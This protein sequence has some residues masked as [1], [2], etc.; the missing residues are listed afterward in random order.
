MNTS[1]NIPDIRI[2]RDEAMSAHVDDLLK[3]QKSLLGESGIDHGPRHWYYRSW[4]VLMLVGAM[5]A[6]GAWAL[7][8][9]F[10]DDTPY[11]QG[12]I[13]AM[14]LDAAIPTRI[15]IGEQVVD[16]DLKGR[17]WIQVRNEKIWLLDGTRDILADETTALL[18][19]AALQRGQE[20]GVHA[21]Y[22]EFAEQ[23]LAVA[24]FVL[25]SPPPDPPA[26]AS[27]SLRRQAV[28]ADVWSLLLFP[29]VAGFIGLAI[30]AVDGIICRTPRRALL[31]GV[32]GCVV[33][34]VGGAVSSFLGN[35]VYAPLTRLA[36]SEMSEAEGLTAFGFMMQMGA[37]T[38]AW[39]LV[40]MAMGLGQGIALRS[41][42]LLAYGF[43]GG[44]VGGLLG[45]LFFDP[46]D[47]L[48]L[49]MD[50]P[51]AHWSRLVGITAI[52]ACVGAMIGVVELLARDAWLRM[53]EGPLAGKE[54]LIFKDTMKLGSSA[55]AEIYLFNDPMVAEHHATLR[56]V[57]DDCEIENHDAEHPVLVNNRAVTVARLRRG[58]RITIGRT[59]FVY[60][61]RRG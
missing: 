27:F 22:Q 41:K 43:M 60:E 1:G 55:R 20:V 38:L 24:R 54:F 35:L 50:K 44:V 40:G 26:K 37:R 14:D 8:E 34:F 31:G 59:A 3:R 6:F 11:L 25:T 23:S 30:G 28:R 33:G 29:V 17:G 56:A 52:G 21:H 5:A 19:R 13:E 15:T 47:L 10:F 36:T 51:S 9:P 53:I 39:G 46:I 49:G 58:D 12:T 57:G 45:G 16:L 7:S 2:T 4:F 48:L 61:N 42:R 18:D 32:L